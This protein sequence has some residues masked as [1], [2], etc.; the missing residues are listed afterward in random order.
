MS[1][2]VIWQT[3]KKISNNKFYV[4]GKLP[5]VELHITKSERK[6]FK[7]M[8]IQSIYGKGRYTFDNEKHNIDVS[9]FCAFFKGIEG[10]KEYYDKAD[11]ASQ[12]KGEKF[13]YTVFGTKI[14]AEC[15]KVKNRRAEISSV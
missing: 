12:A 14:T 7:G 2:E 11:K 13:I 10:Y 1:T 4:Y 9:K 15:D 5:Q 3:V 6:E 8:F